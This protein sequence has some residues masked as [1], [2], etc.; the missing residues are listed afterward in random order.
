[1]V[2]L[3]GVAA[4]VTH[5]FILVSIEHSLGR[6]C[7]LASYS[8]TSREQVLDE[9]VD[10]NVYQRLPIFADGNIGPLAV[11]PLQHTTCRKYLSS[12]SINAD[13]GGGGQCSPLTISSTLVSKLGS[14]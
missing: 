7:L 6:L 12:A 1:M 14:V 2:A 5:G 11:H 8:A 9:C 10:A 13:G 3:E 4:A